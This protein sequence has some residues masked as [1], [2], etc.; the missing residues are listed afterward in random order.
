MHFFPIQDV[1]PFNFI[2]L[3]LFMVSTRIF[4]I[5]PGPKTPRKYHWTIVL[6]HTHGNNKVAWIPNRSPLRQLVYR[7]TGTPMFSN[8]WQQANTPTWTT[9]HA[10]WADFSLV[11]E[12]AK[13]NCGCV[14]GKIR[15]TGLTVLAAWRMYDLIREASALGQVH[16]VSIAY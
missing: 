15:H 1:N 12:I 7:L 4:L 5:W 16:R 11:I 10:P 9:A 8:Q 13:C 14:D 6:D 3:L 2:L